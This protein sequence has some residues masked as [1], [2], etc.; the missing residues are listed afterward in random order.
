[1]Q[2]EHLETPRLLLRALTP[3]VYKY[4]FSNYNQDQIKQFFGCKTEKEFLEEK[5]K[6][7]EG[8]SMY[9]KSLK[10][11]QLIEKQTKDV[12]GWCGFHTWYTNHARAEIGYVLSDDSKKKMGFMKEAL[13]VIINYG[14]QNM[15]LK[16]IEAMVGADNVPS[17]K[18]LTSLGFQQ[19]GVLREH[20]FVNDVYEDSL[21]FSLLERE[22]QLQ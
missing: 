14:F 22:F 2:F 17:L 8:L 12:I 18:L 21:M 19:E 15:K 10:L 4:V 1:M 7:D 20:Y 9:R 6:H 13:P 16:R 5:K 11:F 3:D